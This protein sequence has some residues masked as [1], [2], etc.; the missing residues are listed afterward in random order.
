MEEVIAEEKKNSDLEPS[1]LL[2]G[3]GNTHQN[4][5]VF[6]QIWELAHHRI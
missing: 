5:K 2:K 4:A 3:E 1:M 6:C